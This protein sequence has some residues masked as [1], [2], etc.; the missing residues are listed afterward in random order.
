MS[1]GISKLTTPDCSAGVLLRT[2]PARSHS[3]RV[4]LGRSSICCLATTNL[5]LK[6][7]CPCHFYCDFPLSQSSCTTLAH[8]LGVLWTYLGVLVAKKR[9]HI[10][11]KLLHT[12]AASK[13]VLNKSGI[14]HGWGDKKYLSTYSLLTRSLA[15]L[16]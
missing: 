10:P 9:F 7:L 5:D 6:L 14:F 8:L 16:C 11:G 2:M 12:P 13:G 15:C 4:I 1:L 3:L